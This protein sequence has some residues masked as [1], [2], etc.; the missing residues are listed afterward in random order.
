MPVPRSVALLISVLI[1]QAC[2]A[3]A[4]AQDSASISGSVIA[5]RRIAYLYEID[6]SAAAQSFTLGVS[7][8]TLSSAGLLVRLTDLDGLSQDGTPNPTSVD[9]GGAAGPGTT[10]ASL[11][12]TYDGVRAFVVEIE[13]FGA[14]SASFSGSVNTTAGTIRLLEQEQ[15]NLGAPGLKVIVNRIADYSASVGPGQVIPAALDLD[16]GPLSQTITIRFEAVGSGLSK[17]ELWDI[18]GGSATPLATWTS[19]PDQDVIF[20]THSGIATLRVNVHGAGGGSVAW[21]LIVPGG[22]ALDRPGALDGG[23][24]GGE[25]SCAARESRG[26]ALALFAWVLFALAR[27]RRS[28][29]SR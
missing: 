17:V 3:A 27:S 10:N 18:T 11:S 6:F 12:G 5:G 29:S 2:A 19:L 25:S 22:I 26:G 14:G 16:F 4:L 24:D 9:Q 23:G 8:N 1:L 20:L 13:T 21:S 28:R 15:V 7:A